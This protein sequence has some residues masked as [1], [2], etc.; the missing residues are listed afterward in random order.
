MAKIM[1]KGRPFQKGQSGNPLGGKLHNPELRAIKRLTS[2]E[3]AEIG[4]LVVKK[5]LVG[6]KA[7][8]NDP[9]SSALKVWM[10]SIAIRVDG[11]VHGR[12]GA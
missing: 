9:E 7:V 11:G 1:P 6:L 12:A 10:A 5:N 4:S 3:V 2:A 8:A